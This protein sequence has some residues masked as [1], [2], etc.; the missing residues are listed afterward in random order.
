MSE[1]EKI[2]IVFVYFIIK[3]RENGNNIVDMIVVVDDFVLSFDF[4]YFFYV[5]LFLKI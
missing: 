2:V 5:Y 4:N 3:F 1:G